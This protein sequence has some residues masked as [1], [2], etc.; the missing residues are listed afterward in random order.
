[1]AIDV[2]ALEAAV[3]AQKGVVPSVK[4][5]IQELKDALAAELA[6]DP[7]A[8]AAV[9]RAMDAVLSHNADLAAAIQANP[10]P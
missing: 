6:N 4:T 7:T 10:T 8:Q 9:N 2:S 1:M 3:E 5:F